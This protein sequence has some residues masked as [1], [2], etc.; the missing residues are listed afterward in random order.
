VFHLYTPLFTVT[1]GG[2]AQPTFEAYGAYV[3]GQHTKILAHSPLRLFA[4]NLEGYENEASEDDGM[5]GDLVYPIPP[6]HFYN[7]YPTANALL[8]FCQQPHSSPPQQFLPPALGST[9]TPIPWPILFYYTPLAMPFPLPLP[10][11]PQTRKGTDSKARNKARK[12]RHRL[13]RKRGPLTT[14]Y[15]APLCLALRNF[16][17]IATTMAG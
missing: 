14:P 16:T 5:G 9:L 7:Q 4:G 15:L 12:A 11:H 8:P 17:S 1:H 13:K 6:P 10:Q 3:L 2:L